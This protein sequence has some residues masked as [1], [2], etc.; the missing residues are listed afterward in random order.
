MIITIPVILTKMTT[1]NFNSFSVVNQFPGKTM[2]SEAIFDLL[3]CLPPNVVLL[4]GGCMVC[5]L[6]PYRRL[7]PYSRLKSY[8]RAQTRTLN[9]NVPGYTVEEV[10]D[11]EPAP[12]HLQPRQRV[13]SIDQQATDAQIEEI[14]SEESIDERSGQMVPRKESWI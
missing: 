6:I 2:Q 10:E 5:Y 3:S 14:Q 12:Q 7:I 11:V 1:V 9:R 13:L 8:R 4:I